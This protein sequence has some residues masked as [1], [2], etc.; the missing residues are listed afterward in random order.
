[1]FYN[2]FFDTQSHTQ[3]ITFYPIWGPT[4]KP[5]HVLIIYGGTFNKANASASWNMGAP[6]TK[7]FA[8]ENA[9]TKDSTDLA[10]GNRSF[11]LLSTANMGADVADRLS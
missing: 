7:V 2:I 3:S 1:M 4:H 10:I 9:F 11:V 6:S 8:M 5:R